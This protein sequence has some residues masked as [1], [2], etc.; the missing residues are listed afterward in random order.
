AAGPDRLFA[1]V[2]GRRDGDGKM[3]PLRQIATADVPPILHAASI[4]KR[5][6]LIKEMVITFVENRPVRIVHPLRRC[7]DVKN[8]PRRI[9]LRARDGGLDSSGGANQGF[10]IRLALAANR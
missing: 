1:F 9:S 3:F 2:A 4:G 6:E 10:L 5:V 8:R 7:S